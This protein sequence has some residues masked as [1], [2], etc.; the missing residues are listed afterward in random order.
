MSAYVERHGVGDPLLLLHG[1]LETVDM[2]AELTAALAARYDV[3]APERRG[4]GRTVDVPGPITYAAMADDTLALAD[5][6][7]IARTHVVGYSDGANVAMLLAMAH[8]E[9]VNRLV[10]V[11]GNFRADG[12]IRPFRLGLRRATAETYAPEHAEAHRAL[13]P[14]GPEH[15]PVVFEKVRRMW[16]EEPTLTAADLALVAAPTLVLAGK[17]DYVAVEHTIALSDGIPG[18]RLILLPGGSHGLLTK[19]PARTTQLILEFLG[20]PP[21]GRGSGGSQA[22]GS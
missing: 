7:G 10:L 6:L 8:P 12:M 21:H 15:W 4:H 20:A 13:S 19:E 11:S 3:I 1:G 5:V 16:L 9:R 17:A 2:L 22:T 14:D 18:A